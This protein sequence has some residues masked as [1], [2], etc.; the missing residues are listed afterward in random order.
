MPPRYRS[1]SVGIFTVVAFLFGGLSGVVVGALSQKY[2]VRGFEAGFAIMGAA[3]VV[4]ALLMAIAFFFT[5]RRD[6]IAEA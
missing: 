3:Y 6:R 5:F 4:G 2:G 1:T